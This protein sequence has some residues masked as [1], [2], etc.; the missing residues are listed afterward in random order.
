MALN[1]TAQAWQEDLD[2]WGDL[3]ADV[4]MLD[5]GAPATDFHL[6]PEEVRVMFA[7]LRD[8]AQGEPEEAEPNLAEQ[9]AERVAQN[10]RDNVDAGAPF[11]WYDERTDDYFT[12]R[13]D[14]PRMEAGDFDPD[15]VD[16]YDPDDA[17]TA[18]FIDSIRPAW[19]GMYVADAF[20]FR[21]VIGADRSYLNGEVCI[22]LGGPNVWIS[23]DERSVT[24]YWGDKATRSLPAAFIDGIDEALSE[25][26]SEGV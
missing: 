14:V 15:D 1:E 25:M 26:W 7:A 16:G 23:T 10:I 6:A 4:T 11:G 18:P 20:D 3:S 21:Y 2:T 8:S 12:D 22:A 24:V 19:G 9:Y 13:D 5:N 17:L